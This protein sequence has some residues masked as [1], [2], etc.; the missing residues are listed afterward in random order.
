M[1]RI[2]VS[3]YVEGYSEFK[4]EVVVLILQLFLR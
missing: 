3:D 4:I 2:D 1:K